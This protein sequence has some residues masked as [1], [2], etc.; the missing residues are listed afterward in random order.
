M[1]KSLSELLM[2]LEPDELLSIQSDTHTQGIRVNLV[3]FVYDLDVELT[4][5]LSHIELLQYR[6][7]LLYDTVYQMLNE[8]RAGK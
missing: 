5:V 7:D 4:R 8:L 3:S 1:N 2:T 6:G